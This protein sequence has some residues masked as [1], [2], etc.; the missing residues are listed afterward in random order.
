MAAIKS[1]SARDFT[2]VSNIGGLAEVFTL[3]I[4]LDEPVVAT[5][6][7]VSGN[8]VMPSLLVEA[9]LIAPSLIDF[10]AYSP[11]AKTLT[12]QVTLPQGLSSPRITLD[13]LLINDI[14]L[15]GAKGALTSSNGLALTAAY[16]VDTL[17]PVIGNLETNLSIDENSAA[18][19]PL[20]RASASDNNGNVSYRLAGA[21]AAAFAVGSCGATTQPSDYFFFTS[22]LAV[23]L[24]LFLVAVLLFVACSLASLSFNNFTSSRNCSLCAMTLF[25]V[26]K[27]CS[28]FLS[29]SSALLSCPL[30]SSICV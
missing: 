26:F 25:M 24:A 20:F 7:V 13:G 30:I 17:A 12:Y 19:T 22:G 4:T 18:S 11:S 15:Q 8:T 5:R 2:G 29:V 21:D 28:C 3:T 1:I 6:G 27:S 10:V 16:I 23:S 9:Q 14:T